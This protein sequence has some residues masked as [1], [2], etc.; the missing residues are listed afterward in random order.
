MSET[1]LGSYRCIKEYQTPYPNSIVF[2]EGEQV[3][4]GEEY[5]QDPTWK[6]WFRCQG[7]EGQVA[8][9]P[10]DYL[11]KDNLHSFLLKDYDAKE[12]NLVI[13]EIVKIT[14]V[15]GGFGKAINMEGKKG[16]VPINHL[17][18]ISMD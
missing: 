8:W 13:D 5:D 1:V 17:E 12:L 9:I 16:W 15:I 3:V 6:G 2:R 18:P 7:T 11:E 10:I 14:E 4:V